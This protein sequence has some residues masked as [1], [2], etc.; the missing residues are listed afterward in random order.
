MTSSREF[1]DPAFPAFWG[2]EL[3]PSFAELRIEAGTHLL[4]ENNL[5]TFGERD[6]R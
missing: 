4:D 3:S 2:T 6:R 5:P 1:I